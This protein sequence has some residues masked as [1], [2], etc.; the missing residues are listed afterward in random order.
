M[1]KEQSA[2]LQNM[3]V[4]QARSVLIKFDHD[5]SSAFDKSAAAYDAFTRAF[6]MVNPGMYIQHQNLAAGHF[7]YEIGA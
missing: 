6:E 5:P 4:R 3:T 7:F 2:W 1:T